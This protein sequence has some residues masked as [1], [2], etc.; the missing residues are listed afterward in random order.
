MVN[1]GE[2]IYRFNKG[3][4]LYEESFTARGHDYEDKVRSAAHEICGA[5]EWILKVYL[6]EYCELPKDVNRHLIKGKGLRENIINWVFEHGQGLS[7]KNKSAL[8]ILY[9]YRNGGEHNGFI[10]GIEQLYNGIQVMREILINYLE[11]GEEELVAVRHYSGTKAS[12]TETLNKYYAM[13]CAEYKW[14]DFAGLQFEVPV[15]LTMDDF[16]SVPSLYQPKPQ[17]HTANLATDL[18][19]N[20]KQ[21]TNIYDA[22]EHGRVIIL[23]EAGAGKSSLLRYLAYSIAGNKGVG[24]LFHKRLLPLLVTATELASASPSIYGYL[25]AS[26]L[27]RDEY[28]EL[29]KAAVEGEELLLLVDGLDEVADL[30]ARRKLVRRIREFFTQFPGNRLVITSRKV[31]FEAN[32]FSGDYKSLELEGLNQQLMEEISRRWFSLGQGDSAAAQF[33]QEVSSSPEVYNLAKNPLLLV[34]MLAIKQTRGKIPEHRVA[35]FKAAVETMVLVRPKT[36][37]SP[38][39]R[40]QV[41]DFL[42]FV[43]FGMVESGK[44][45]LTK[46]EIDAYINQYNDGLPEEAFAFAEHYTGIYTSKN[47]KYSFINYSILEYLASCHLAKLWE[48]GQLETKWLKKN[49]HQAQWYQIMLMAPGSMGQGLE[50]FLIAIMALG[51]PYEYR[52]FR[53]LFLAADMLWERP[54]VSIELVHDV[55]FNLYMVVTRTMGSSRIEIAQGYIAKLTSIYPVGSYQHRRYIQPLQRIVN[56]FTDSEDTEFNLNLLPVLMGQGSLE[57]LLTNFTSFAKRGQWSLLETCIYKTLGKP[58]SYYDPNTYLLGLQ[59]GEILYTYPVVIADLAEIRD[60]ALAKDFPMYEIEMFLTEDDVPEVEGERIYLIN[61]ARLFESLE[62]NPWVYYQTELARVLGQV[63]EKGF[64]AEL[65]SRLLAAVT[66]PTE[67][68]DSY[69][70]AALIFLRIIA[71]WGEAALPVDLADQHKLQNIVLYDQDEETR[72]DALELLFRVDQG[73]GIWADTQTKL[74]DSAGPVLDW[75]LKLSGLTMEQDL[76][77]QWLEMTFKL[78]PQDDSLRGELRSLDEL[79]K[80]IKLTLD[81]SQYP[82]QQRWFLEFA[83]TTMAEFHHLEPDFVCYLLQDKISSPAPLPEVAKIIE[84][85]TQN[86]TRT[87]NYGLYGAVLWQMLKPAGESSLE[88]LHRLLANKLFRS[89]IIPLLKDGELRDQGIVDS[90]LKILRSSKSWEEQSHAADA[91]SKAQ[92]RIRD[93]I[94]KKLTSSLKWKWELFYCPHYF[95]AISTLLDP[96]SQRRSSGI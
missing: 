25:T 15:E 91:L 35:L 5:Q 12:S 54:P 23:G 8:D 14:V 7:Q 52:L 94:L 55:L 17:Q 13:L 71:A 37:H 21:K 72:I 81:F 46:P 31:G 60:L 29:V 42:G 24:K 85:L 4:K 50:K 63:R 47:G 40:E 79:C 59:R 65:V 80:G 41:L 92:G 78:E 1:R 67:F 3:C 58:R 93:Y 57:W 44:N 53:D 2:A 76:V 87:D 18:A 90:L 48:Q 68:A 88:H 33:M 39:F 70:N 43:A 45:Q 16:Y 32:L 27:D 62:Q 73:T 49:A 64:H 95:T 74:L 36:E 51:S 6:L 22:V 89:T 9:K 61:T 75:A 38:A 30:Q 26:A 69:R 86:L 56:K 34:I 11:A 83:L 82:Q 96:P 77:Q 84:A 20:L 66:A 28:Q 10:V 19:L